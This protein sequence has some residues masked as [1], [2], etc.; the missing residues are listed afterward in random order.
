MCT[1]EIDNSHVVRREHRSHLICMLQ[2]PPTSLRG[3]RRGTS[4]CTGAQSGG[5]QVDLGGADGLFRPIRRG[6]CSSPHDTTT[7]LAPS[8]RL[9]CLSTPAQRRWPAVA[10]AR[11]VQGNAPALRSP[12]WNHFTP[13]HFS[14]LFSSCPE[15]T[16]LSAARC[17]GDL[18]R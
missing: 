7:L 8:S 10:F 15:L 4:L 9:C 1:E 6:T 5:A 14:T 13:H 11:V 16:V 12:S 18:R 3:R 2:P 17:L